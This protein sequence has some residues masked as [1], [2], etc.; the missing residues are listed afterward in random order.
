MA[1][2]EILLLL[3]RIC[4]TVYKVATGTYVTIHATA[5]G[6]QAALLDH[7]QDLGKTVTPWVDCSRATT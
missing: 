3:S 5:A 4:A 7:G 2:Y 6:G 1:P